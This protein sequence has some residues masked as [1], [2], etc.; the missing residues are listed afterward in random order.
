MFGNKRKKRF[1]KVLLFFGGVL[2]LIVLIGYYINNG[3]NFKVNDISKINKNLPIPNNLKNP[4]KNNNSEN[5]YK[6]NKSTKLY[7]STHFKKCGHCIE[8]H[9]EAPDFFIGL[10]IEELKGKIYG[11]EIDSVEDD[12]IH[13]IKEINT[14]CPE[15]FII[16]VEDGNIAIFKYSENGEKILKEVTDIDI[17]VLTPEDQAFLTGGIVTDTEDDMERKLEGFSN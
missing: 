1:K 12:N 7:Y 17:N 11:W 8:K 4:I 13:F 16:G 15:H 10:S 3:Q 14:F 6:I 5:L 2:L 9:I